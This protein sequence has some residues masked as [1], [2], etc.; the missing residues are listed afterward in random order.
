MFH[1]KNRMAGNESSRPSGFCYIKSL[2]STRQTEST[3][4]SKSVPAGKDGNRLDYPHYIAYTETVQVPI[5][6]RRGG[7]PSRE[8]SKWPNFDVRS[9]DC[10]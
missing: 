10:R 9:A 2:C 6:P 1:L 7:E 5:Y 3:A 4:Q 8:G